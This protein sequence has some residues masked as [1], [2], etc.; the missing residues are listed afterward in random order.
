MALTDDDVREILRL[1][2]ESE[3]DELRIETDGLSLH[4]LRGGKAPPPEPAA[5]PAEAAAPVAVASDD[6][7]D[8]AGD[9]STIASPMLGTF[10]RAPAPGAPPF[11]EVGTRVEPDT[12]V[13]IIEVMKMMNSIPAGV[14]GTIAEIH[15][16]NAELV[17]YAQPLFRVELA[18]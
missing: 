10:Y 6:G 3:L 1:I 7:H 2:D 11:V 17:E 12:I 14:A 5:H 4:V 13:C 15:A 9:P 8:A 16:E 18:S